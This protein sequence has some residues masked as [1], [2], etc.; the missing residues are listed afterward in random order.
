MKAF[1][2]VLLLEL[3]RLARTRTAAW[4]VAACAAWMFVLPHIATSDGTAEG[5]W[6]L[7]VQLS[8]GGVF[9]ICCISLATAGACS[10]S[11]EREEFRLALSRVRP[12]PRFMLALGRIV[13]LTLL[14][15]A[16]LAVSFAILIAR[17]DIERRCDHVKSPVMESPHEEAEKAYARYLSLMP[18]L[19]EPDPPQELVNV[20]TAITNTPKATIIRLLTQKALDRYE[21]V[22]TN[23]AASWRFEVPQEDSSRR[24]SVRMRF[25]SDFNLRDDVNGVFSFCG[26]TGSVSNITKTVA[27]IP[28]A[29]DFAV[30]MTSESL[31]FTNKGDNTLMLRPRKDIKLL[32]EADSFGA[33]AIRAY[34]Q[35]VSI[36]SAICAFAV[37]LGSFLGR[38]VAVFSCMVMLFVGAVSSDVIVSYPDELESDRV[39]RIS[40]AITRTVEMASRPLNSFSPVTALANDECVE[41]SQTALVIALDGIAIPLLFSLLC[42]FAISRTSCT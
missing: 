3:R 8:V 25:S 35:L 33:N 11:R 13:A 17:T 9:A 10:L 21:T 29:G 4:L 41:P 42:A 36:L 39:D 37:F 7:S 38:T 27:K 23:S 14:G 28:L 30:P 2:S 32:I 26:L 24:I 34:L 40:L 22:A 19:D 20:L 18:R 12:A 16:A 1:L 5:A 31:T 6:T 15:A